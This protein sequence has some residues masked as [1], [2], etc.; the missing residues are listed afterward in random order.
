[1][2][3]RCSNPKAHRYDLYGGRGIRVCKKWLKFDGFWKDMQP[4]YRP[5]LTLDRKDRDKGYFK[6]NCVWADWKTQNRHT[7]NCRMLTYRGET[8]AM[9]EWVEI[10]G[11]PRGTVKW[12]L[13]KGYPV[14]TALEGG[15]KIGRPKGTK[16][17]APA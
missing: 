1:M 9:S 6:R 5:N 3:Q 14:K 16:T 11:V 10:L 7:T 13:A 4:D 2:K 15:L 17:K 8:R 12:R